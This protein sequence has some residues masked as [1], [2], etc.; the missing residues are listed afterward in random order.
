MVKIESAD[1]AKDLALNFLANM[2]EVVWSAEIESIRK[3]QNKWLIQ[4]KSIPLLDKERTIYL[5]IDADTGRV[6]SYEKK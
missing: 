3:S 1:Q 6:L 4:I 5:E 2:G